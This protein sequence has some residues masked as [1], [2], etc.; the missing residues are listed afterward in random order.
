M[1]AKALDAG[2]TQRG[3]VWIVED[4]TERRR[5]DE[6]AQRAAAEQELILDNASVGIAFVRN[7]AIRRCNRFLEDMVGAGPGELVGESSAVLFATEEGWREA[8]LLAYGTTAPEKRTTANGNSS[9]ATAPSFIAAPAA[10][11]SMR[12][13]G[14]GMDLELRGCHGER[15]AEARVQ[16]PWTPSSARWP[17]APRS[18]RM[19]KPA[20]ST[21]PAM[22]R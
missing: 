10:G 7:R 4:V 3:T 9:A 14:A 8:G 19:R 22:T 11:A 18:W 5:A 13:R 21:W 2:N 15:E 17:S 12:G 20:P 16:Q 6:R 1:I